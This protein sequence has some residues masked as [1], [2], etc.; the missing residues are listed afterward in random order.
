MAGPE[1]SVCAKQDIL[2]YAAVRSGRQTMK[3]LTQEQVASYHHDGFLFPI[4]ALT[5]EEIATCL[6]GLTGWRRNWLPRRRR[7]RQMALPRLCAFA[8][9][10]QPDPPSPNP[11][12]DRGRDRPQHPGL[13]QHVLH[14][15][16][17]LADL[18]RLAPGRHLFRPGSARA[19]LRL[20][21]ADR[22]QPRGR[23]HGTSVQPRRPAPVAPRAAGPGEQ[24]QPRRP[25]DHGAVR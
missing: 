2:K 4:P 7:G 3:A 18:R 17:A 13:D 15:G 5:P 23:L 25:D 1:I 14:Q 20:G 11:G 16:A 9:V 10:Q 12:R 8:L 6:A 22:C 19:G 24:H 21:R